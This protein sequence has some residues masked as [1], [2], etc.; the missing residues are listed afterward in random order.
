MQEVFKV[1]SVKRFINHGSNKVRFINVVRVNSDICSQAVLARA[2][3]GESML[4]IEFEITAELKGSDKPVAVFEAVEQL[5]K[6]G[7]RHE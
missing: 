5:N 7:V 3:S 4:R 2:V 6:K 1:E